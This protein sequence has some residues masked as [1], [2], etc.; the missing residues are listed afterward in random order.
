MK[1][2]TADANKNSI[3]Y[4]MMW[5]LSHFG[6]SKYIGVE[7]DAPIQGLGN[8]TY[9]K[10]ILNSDM[11]LVKAVLGEPNWDLDSINCGD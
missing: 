7:V 8:A 5:E 1:K 11:E 2:D 9:N 6:G 3:T 10:F 4:K